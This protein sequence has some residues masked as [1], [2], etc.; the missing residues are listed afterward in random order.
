MYPTLKQFDPSQHGCLIDLQRHYPYP[1]VY[2]E[3]TPASGG[4]TVKRWLIQVFGL[5]KQRRID[6]ASQTLQAITFCPFCGELL[7]VG[8][9]EDLLPKV[10]PETEPVMTA[11]VM[12][13]Y[14]H[15]DR[16]PE[17]ENDESP[18]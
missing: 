17:P 1:F 14:V 2:A 13:Q 9:V 8:S 16:P 5:T 10:E 6:E 4:P 7:A 18:A 15:E 11:A 12:E 3:A